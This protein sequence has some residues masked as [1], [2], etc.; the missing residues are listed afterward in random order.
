M[1]QCDVRWFIKTCP[2]QAAPLLPVDLTKILI[3]N[4]RFSELT[5]ITS[6]RQTNT[7]FIDR[8]EVITDLFVIEMREIYVHIYTRLLT[9]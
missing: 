9:C 2:P 4:H 3:H 8:K 1:D 5:P 7:Y 6:R